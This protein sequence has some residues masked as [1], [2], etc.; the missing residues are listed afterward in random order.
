MHLT[1]SSQRINAYTQNK[2][3]TRKICLQWSLEKEKNF[4]SLFFAYLF[5]TMSILLMFWCRIYYNYSYMSPHRNGTFVKIVLWILHWKLL[6]KISFDF[7]CGTQS[8]FNLCFILKITTFKHKFFLCLS[9]LPSNPNMKFTAFC[10]LS[11]IKAFINVLK[12]HNKQT[13]LVRTAIESK[14]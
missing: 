8:R 11:A 9:Q 13:K 14:F 6:F 4:I 12:S 2:I 3:K 10:Q 7:K 5:I 1:E